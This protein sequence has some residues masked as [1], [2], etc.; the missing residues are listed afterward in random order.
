MGLV[1]LVSGRTGSSSEY[2]DDAGP[3]TGTNQCLI[4]TNAP[5]DD[6]R[7]VLESRHEEGSYSCTISSHRSLAPNICSTKS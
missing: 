4:V 6:T 3:Q 2:L 7:E 5:Q 1:T